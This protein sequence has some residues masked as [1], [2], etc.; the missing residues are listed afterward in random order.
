MG[1]VTDLYAASILISVV[2]MRMYTIEFGNHMSPLSPN[3]Y[4]SSQ[5]HHQERQRLFRDAW[6]LAGHISQLEINTQL[7]LNIAG[8]PIVLWRTETEI[9]AFANM[10]RHRG[11]PLVWEGERQ[12]GTKLRCRY[13]GWTYDETGTLV[14]N[15]DFGDPCQR[16]Q[17]HNLQVWAEYGWIFVAWN[18]QTITPHEIYPT[19]FKNISGME[20]WTVR[21]TQRH[22]LKCNWKVYVE[23]YLEGY[24]IPYLHPSL[25]KEISMASYSVVIRER[26]MEH[27]VDTKEGTTSEGYWAYCWPNLAVN[28][29][30][31]GVSMERIL[32]MS[33]NETVIEYWYLFPPETTQERVDKAIHLSHQVTLE[34]IQVVEAIQ[35]SM[36]SGLY[37]PGPLS[38]K[39]EHG[40]DAFQS[41][42][43]ECLD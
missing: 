37:E 8:I 31:D 13:H 36:E 27:R 17:L 1:R 19:L 24:H 18:P 39:H 11:A 2:T 14:N 3:H 43:G 34:D 35:V 6:L 15:T 10:C 33:V 7:A 20:E 5:K 41:W 12:R 9:K 22:T 28:K 40:L 26:E 42:V 4:T 30:S 32:P 21:S 29:Y 23:N 25:T 38:P 16:L